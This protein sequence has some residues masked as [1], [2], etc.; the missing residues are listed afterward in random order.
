MIHWFNLILFQNNLIRLSFKGMQ[1]KTVAKSCAL[2]HLSASIVIKNSLCKESAFFL[3]LKVTLSTITSLLD[4]TYFLSTVK[5][6]SL[7]L[8]LNYLLT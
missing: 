6:Y 7:V 1:K 8:E 5:F 4:P 2:M 3:Y